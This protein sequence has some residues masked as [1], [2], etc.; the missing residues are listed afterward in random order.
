MWSSRNGKNWL[1][2]SFPSCPDAVWTEKLAAATARDKRVAADLK[3][4]VQSAAKVEARAAIEGCSAAERNLYQPNSQLVR[5]A[6]QTH[7]HTH[8]QQGGMLPADGFFCVAMSGCRSACNWELGRE[9]VWSS[10]LGHR[11]RVGRRR[12]WLGAGEYGV[13]DWHYSHVC[14]WY[15]CHCSDNH[16]RGGVRVDLRIFVSAIFMTNHQIHCPLHRVVTSVII[17]MMLIC[18]ARG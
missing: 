17:A 5:P 9:Y 13:T 18:Q 8:S 2:P 11:Q 12:L 3:R 6:N 15:C 16:P 7:A 1:G 14:Y 4:Q 10:V